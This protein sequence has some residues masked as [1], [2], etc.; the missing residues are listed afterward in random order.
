MNASL[1]KRCVKPIK[2]SWINIRSR[3][4][5]QSIRSYISLKRHLPLNITC[6]ALLDF[7]ALSNNYFK[8]FWYFFLHACSWTWFLCL[9]HTKRLLAQDVSRK[10]GL[11]EQNLE[12]TCAS[13]LFYNKAQCYTNYSKGP[14][15]VQNWWIKI[16]IFFYP[17]HGDLLST[18]YLGVNGWVL[19]RKMNFKLNVLLW[20]ACSALWKSNMMMHHSP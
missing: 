17:Y 15:L 9:G 19:G 12:S 3:L 4:W 1:D 5:H 13:I 14:Y 18:D 20:S 7:N 11:S 16:W 10:L 6:C 2:K 8:R